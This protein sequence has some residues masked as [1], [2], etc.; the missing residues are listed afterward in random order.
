MTGKSDRSLWAVS[1]K[2]PCCL[3]A[4]RKEIPAAAAAV[5]AREPRVLCRGS[6]LQPPM[7]A[8]T[9]PR[10]LL[11]GC[12][13]SSHAPVLLD[14]LQWSSSRYA[15]MKLEG[16]SYLSGSPSAP[17]PGVEVPH[18]LWGGLLQHPSLRL[19]HSCWDLLFGAAWKTRAAPG[20]PLHLRESSSQAASAASLKGTLL[21]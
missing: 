16:D 17:L 12:W 14:E 3:A 11:L 2:T 13:S 21:G 5:A 18:P 6:S 20:V 4:R 1:Q 10:C 15:Q 9:L 7:A 8:Q 19:I